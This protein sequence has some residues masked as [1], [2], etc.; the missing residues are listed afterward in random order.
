[1][2]ASDGP[3]K[4]QIRVVAQTMVLETAAIAN[5]SETFPIVRRRW[6]V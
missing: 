5:V 1:M 3:V 2:A 6:R 4:H